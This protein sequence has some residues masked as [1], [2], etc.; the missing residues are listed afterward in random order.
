MPK[1]KIKEQQGKSVKPQRSSPLSEQEAEAFQTLQ[2]ENQ[3][4]RDLVVYLT[5][6][7][8]RN[9]GVDPAR[10]ARTVNSADSKQL[11]RA[12]DILARPF[13]GHELLTHV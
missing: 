5:A 11:N 12:L 10:D 1:S 7:V 2:A 3:R 6:A 4:L 13:P 9:M 8:L